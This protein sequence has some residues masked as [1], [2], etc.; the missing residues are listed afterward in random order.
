[1]LSIQE[2]IKYPYKECD[3]QATTKGHLTQQLN[4]TGKNVLLT[5]S[6]R[7]MTSSLLLMDLEIYYGQI[8]NNS[9]NNQPRLAESISVKENHHKI[10]Y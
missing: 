2:G 9:D 5:G 4:S 8:W 7:F 1:M 10:S 6:E 3:Y